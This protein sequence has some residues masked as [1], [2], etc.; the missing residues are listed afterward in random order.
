MKKKVYIAMAMLLALAITV[1]A[2]AFTPDE[3]SVLS[4]H[5]VG[6]HCE[7]KNGGNVSKS[8]LVYDSELYQD[9]A[10]YAIS[11]NTG[12]DLWLFPSEVV[13]GK[14]KW[15]IQEGQGIFM[16]SI[17]GNTQW[18]SYS[19]ENQVFDGKNVRLYKDTD[20]YDPFASVIAKK[21]LDGEATGGFEFV[22]EREVSPNNWEQIGNSI[23]SEEATG[24]VDFGNRIVVTGKYRIREIN[25]DINSYVSITDTLEFT[26]N[27]NDIEN[28]KIFQGSDFNWN[29]ITKPQT[30]DL[31]ISVD[32][33]KEHDVVTWR[34]VYAKDF[35]KVYAQDFYDLFAQDFYDVC[36]QD[37]YDR[38][39]QDYYDIF[40]QDFYDTYAQDFYDVFAQDYYDVYAQDFYDVF[41]QDF[42]NV[43]AQDYYDVYAQDFYDVYAQDFRKIF[44]PVF[45]KKAS[46]VGGTLVTWLEDGKVPGG[47][48]GN[49]MTWL[50]VDIAKASAPE[51]I[52]YTIGDSSPSNKPIN[53]NY[54]V[55]IEGN[56]LVLSLDDRL[57]SAAVTA[58]L[59]SSIPSKHDPSGHTNLTGG[60]ELRVKLPTASASNNNSAPTVNATKNGDDV[61]IT[62]GTVTLTVKFEKN[63]SKNYSLDGGYE[64]KIE[65]NGNGVKSA[66]AVKWPTPVIEEQTP[67]QVIY[68]FVH[69]DG[70][71][72]YTTGQ[73]EFT[74]WQL[75]GTELL[76]DLRFVERISND[77]AALRFVETILDDPAALRFIERII[78]DPAALRFVE[79]VLDDS[80][81]LRFVETVLDDPDAL[82]FVE[83][84]IDDTDAL[85][86]VKICYIDPR[87]LRTEEVSRTTVTDTY[88]VDFDY[89]VYNGNNVVASGKIANK[90]NVEISGLLAG[91][92]VVVLSGDDIKDQRATVTVIAGQEVSVNFND[93]PN[94]IGD[95]DETQLPDRTV[96]GKKFQDEVIIGEKIADQIVE[97][98]K[99]DDKIID[100]VQLDDRIV[101]GVQL[102]D[103]IIDGE[104]L[105]DKVI[106]GVKLA[107]KVIDGVQLDD[108]IVEGVQLVDKIIDGVQ[109]ENK[110]VEGKKLE[111]RVNE[112]I[113]LP[114]VTK[115]GIHL[116]EKDKYLGCEDITANPLIDCHYCEDC[117]TAGAIARN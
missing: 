29:N 98:E 11:G 88:N 50:E 13:A 106:D 75:K 48:F 51:G 79:T 33:T 78:D 20:N 1:P 89:V 47:K 57:I 87:F 24:I 82:R 71:K 96:A 34:N 63:A 3:K 77:P 54:N 100:G 23:L 67:A 39:E 76:D 46:S 109:L 62:V 26:V 6:F 37:F 45:E 28:H 2:M 114:D 55:R 101:E 53:Y 74:G 83:T 92:Y 112:G 21:F 65:Y 80:D 94:I 99:V 16:C 110:N 17:C 43:F 27:Q 90:G 116:P 42:Y 113:Q 4:Q 60:K 52:D 32:V 44:V 10:N 66:T 97:G 73:Y 8:I 107:D 61:T 72:W 91:S 12:K 30:G 103:E 86:F 84:V 18:A 36:A 25:L 111:K 40:A 19:N 85:R 95:D 68:M 59:Y 64:V 41:A 7:C 35:Y 49:S 93:I 22:L 117:K 102:A 70:V 9:G 38:Y 56:E 108:L 15:V 115:P 69:F 14:I 5:G 104:K 58:K 81:A 31:K 105:D